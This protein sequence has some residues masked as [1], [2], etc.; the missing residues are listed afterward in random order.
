M[1]LSDATVQPLINQSPASFD[2]PQF[3]RRGS[4]FLV[5]T[6]R[7]IPPFFV[8]M[9]KRIMAANSKIPAQLEVLNIHELLNPN[10][11]IRLPSVV[12]HPLTL[13]L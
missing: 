10:E 12:F 13:V 3:S 6:L 7:Q 9:I 8:A 4:G 1:N 2:K 11:P 5:G